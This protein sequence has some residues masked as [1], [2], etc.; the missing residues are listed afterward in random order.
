MINK[1]FEL[2]MSNGQTCSQVLIYNESDLQYW[3][4]QAQ[5]TGH[6]IGFDYHVAED[7]MGYPRPAHN[8]YQI[9]PLEQKDKFKRLTLAGDKEVEG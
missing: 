1:R 7:A 4:D 5:K 6:L 2:P 3:K 9:F 8:I